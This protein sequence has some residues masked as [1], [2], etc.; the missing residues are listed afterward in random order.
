M[1]QQ[2]TPFADGNKLLGTYR[3]ILFIGAA[4]FLGL[5]IF[6]EDLLIWAGLTEEVVAGG[7]EEAVL[8]LD[9]TGKAFLLPLRFTFL[10]FVVI[11]L[12]ETIHVSATHS[13]RSLLAK[14]E[15]G[16]KFASVEAFT[17]GD[18]FLGFYQF[19]LV[20][21]VLMGFIAM[22]VTPSLLKGS[23]VK[24]PATAAINLLVWIAY[25]G[26]V[27]FCAFRFH[28]VGLTRDTRTR[29]AALAESAVEE[30]QETPQEASTDAAPV[31]G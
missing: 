17:K 24:P 15:E 20:V 23:G 3:W 30:S 9:K 16:G 22:M 7:A 5:T 2:S 19:F 29:L 14:A 10:A 13:V 27:L 1:T 21:C 12:L 25:I 28:H 8:G 26:P 4:V 11:W 6:T 18:F 31:A